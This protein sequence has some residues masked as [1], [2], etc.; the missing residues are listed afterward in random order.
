MRQLTVLNASE[1]HAVFA[2]GKYF[3][4]PDTALIQQLQQNN[5]RDLYK[6]TYTAFACV[7]YDTVQQTVTAVRD[8]FG[9][10]PFYYSVHQGQ[11][12]FSS[13]I[14]DILK[15]IKSPLK[16]NAN[17]I[18]QL[19]VDKWFGT[20]TYSDETYYDSIYRVEPGC[21][22]I[23]DL[24]LKKS[25]VKRP[26]WDL[27]QCN[28]VI[29]YKDERDYVAH[30]SEL[31]SE[32]VRV[33]VA[34]SSSCAAEFSGGLD[35]SAVVTAAFKRDIDLSLFMHVA[36]PGSGFIDDMPYAQHLINHF[37]LKEVHLIDAEQLDIL[38]NMHE[39][40]Q[41]FAGAAPYNGPVLASNLHHAIAE[42]GHH[43]VLSGV[44]GDECVSGHAPLSVYLPGLMKTQGV[45]MAWK[46]LYQA[47]QVHGRPVPSRLKRSVRLMRMGLSNTQT[48]LSEYEHNL[49]QGPGSH[50][51][52][53]RVEYAA[54]LAKAQGFQYA[55]PLLYPPLVEFCY[56]LPLIKKR[57]A[58]VS[59]CIIRD[60]L[61]QFFSSVLYGKQTKSGSVVPA[62][63]AKTRALFLCDVSY[64]EI[65]G[66]DQ[67]STS[68]TGSPKYATFSSFMTSTY[69][70][71]TILGSGSFAEC[72][73]TTDGACNSGNITAFYNNYITS[74][75]ATNPPTAT[76]L[77]YYAAGQC[78]NFSID[79]I[80]NK[81]CTN[82]GY[83]CYDDWYLPALCETGTD[84]VTGVCTEDPAETMTDKLSGFLVNTETGK[85]SQ[86]GAFG[87]VGCFGA[88]LWTSTE[89][90]GSPNTHAGFQ[91][92]TTAPD[93]TTQSASSKR[94]PNVIRCAR[95]LTPTT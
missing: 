12:I 71:L 72:N 90:S 35:S 86:G 47:Y 89:F 8:H 43:T 1:W 41:Y 62:A 93:N 2:E 60:Y 11:F 45:R 37:G 94:A 38:K 70:S 4:S 63:L 32:A 30:F 44:G 59:R 25:P 28:Q 82:T 36:P 79:D 17:R 91:N 55:Y 46:E 31:L 77:T 54:V 67:T 58:G 76:P 27:K 74:T 81:P 49:L 57:K 34:N 26:F 61:A 51:V 92:A 95:A 14:P 88:V 16:L 3:Y 5:P 50:H 6:R 64:D 78:A 73:G 22:L 84:S 56:Q 85:C 39:Y 66:I 40:A 68:G 65:P 20:E 9:L 33:Q 10:E 19:F 23:L 21:E 48:S 69:P 53:M 80:S 15:H 42:Q 75:P 7:I 52:R 18:Q 24:N 13:N 87:E 29:E 83:I